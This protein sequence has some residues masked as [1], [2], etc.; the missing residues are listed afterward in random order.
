MNHWRHWNSS[1][2]GSL[3]VS[4]STPTS[5]HLISSGIKRHHLD[6]CP[7]RAWCTSL[8]HGYTSHSAMV[9]RCPSF[10]HECRLANHK[11]Y[12]DYSR[13]WIYCEWIKQYACT[14]LKNRLAS[15]WTC[16]R[17]LK[18]V[19]GPLARYVNFRV[20]SR[21]PG[22][23]SPLPWGWGVITTCIT[24][25]AVMHAGIINLRFI[26]KSVAG[27]MFTAFPA[28]AQPAILRIW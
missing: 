23:F 11:L 9:T 25:R 3:A 17:V 6:K 7:W 14:R 1:L 12:Q 15:F 22:T 26:L 18:P 13:L 20:V 21:M 24:A 8:G 19:N 28:H 5:D 10:P 2:D 4:A 16:M 27:K